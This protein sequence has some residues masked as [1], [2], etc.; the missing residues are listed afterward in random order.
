MADTKSIESVMKAALELDFDTWIKVSRAVT[1]A[2][3]EKEHKSR[4]DLKLTEI[5]RIKYFYTMGQF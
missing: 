3:V 1:R 4:V 5:E 2:F